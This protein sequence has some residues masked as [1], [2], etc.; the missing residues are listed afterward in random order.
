MV[1]AD[2]F[3]VA[4]ETRLTDIQREIV[5]ESRNSLHRYETHAALGDCA[6]A[7]ECWKL[8]LWAVGPTRDA[9]AAEIE[10]QVSPSEYG[11][12]VHRHEAML[13]EFVPPQTDKASGLAKLSDGLEIGQDRVLCFGDGGNDVEM[14]A[15]AGLGIAMA[16]AGDAAK[17]AATRVSQWA[18][19]EDAVAQEI[20][21]IFEW[22]AEPE[23][24]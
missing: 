21:A 17:A 5:A 19:H 12:T 4:D 8:L 9:L 23:G 24:G 22:G 20:A 3:P 13:L 10:A 18:H 2:E 15:W 16:N 6:A 14:L 7:A 1:C 11:I